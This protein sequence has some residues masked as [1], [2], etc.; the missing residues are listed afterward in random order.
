MILQRYSISEHKTKAELTKGNVAI[1]EYVKMTVFC[2]KGHQKQNQKEDYRGAFVTY[3]V[4]K[5][6][7]YKT[8]KDCLQIN[9][10]D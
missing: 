10:K 7:I 3:M 2:R 6:I 9:K 8:Y 4:S 1:F 5:G